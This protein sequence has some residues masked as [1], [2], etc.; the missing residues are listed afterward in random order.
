MWSCLAAEPVPPSG[1]NE[2][3]RRL[4][5]LNSYDEAYPWTRGIVTATAATLAAEFNSL[6]M[7]VE[8]MDMRRFT[9]PEH[10]SAFRDFLARK[11]AGRKL[12]AIVA[13]D[14]DAV[15]FLKAQ[16]PDFLAGPPVI[17]GGVSNE[18]VIQSLDRRRFAGVRE[19]YSFA[20]L[21]SV[22][23]HMRPS[24]HHVAVVLDNSENAG[25]FERGCSRAIDA[26]PPLTVEYIRGADLG[27]SGV[28]DRLRLLPA[29]TAVISKAYIVDRD[30][31]N[32]LPGVSMAKIAAASS[33]PVFSPNVTE[34]GQGVL[35]G[36]ANGARQHARA[37][38]SL[39]VRILR[40]TPPADLPILTD[41]TFGPVVDYNALRRWKIPESLL[42]RSVELINRPVS[43]LEL[44]RAWLIGLFIFFLVQSAIIGLLVSNI[45]AR[46]KAVAQRDAQAAELSKRNSEL[47]SLNQSILSEYAARERAQKALR[48]SESRYRDMVENALDGIYTHDLRDRFTAVNKTLCEMLGY[49][50]EEL[51]GANVSMVLTPD[52]A[53]RTREMTARKLAGE[54]SPHYEL[55][56][57]SKNGRHIWIEV[58]SRL[59]WTR[60]FPSGIEGVVRDVTS[61]KSLEE[62]LRQARQMEI[63]G[64]LSG[65][66]AHDFNNILTVVTGY[67]DLLLLTMPPD[68]SA[69]SKVEEIRRAGE[70]ASELTRK[71]LAFGRA[72]ASTNR[73]GDVNKT[74]AECSEMLR[75]LIPAPVKLVLTP[76][77]GLAPV[78]CE[79]VELQQVILNLALNARDAM[80]G[81]GRL[82]IVTRC[83]GN[84]VELSVRDTGQGMDATTR[85]HAFDPFFTTKDP[86][87]GTGLGLSTVYG[88]VHR[89]GGRIEID[90]SP[91]SGSTITVTLPLADPSEAS[92]DSPAE[93]AVP[94]GNGEVIFIVED[95]EEVRLY[96]GEVLRRLGYDPR[97]FGSGD[98]AI[99][100]L[101]DRVRLLMTDV[102]MPGMQGGELARRARL[103]YPDLP[104]LFISGYTG[105]EREVPAE[106]SFLPKP[107]TPSQLTGAIRLALTQSATPRSD[108]A[109]PPA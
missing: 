49:S 72:Q 7:F 40:G 20:G 33:A 97:L 64:R 57:V 79:P 4:L 34:L 91:G 59:I 53:E 62:Q 5:I 35:C 103:K 101:D 80:P 74:I 86:G 25:T 36:N 84:E 31:T 43:P 37:V 28:L 1:P 51:L 60:G 41:G 93:P 107:F 99:E 11:Y 104:V 81:G 54:S 66:V 30:G 83:T 24:T 109:G 95:Q 27:L 61:R 45:L 69:R 67:S 21:V 12:D 82:E 55:T 92:V 19:Q 32:V 73:T 106:G 87:C 94:T 44:Y 17:F 63:L 89:A 105:P 56:A 47:D 13:M 102:V 71:L 98:P 77:T 26:V 75:Y 2:P 3:H 9:G 48:E 10:V 39:A 15:A 14:D 70:R 100:S 42:P 78:R 22:I 85:A 88:I 68:H 46:R 38:A 23:R 108:Q 16:G 50:R 29:G 96:I 65:G 76:E 52:S 58:S 8:Y 6:E 18:E 90:S